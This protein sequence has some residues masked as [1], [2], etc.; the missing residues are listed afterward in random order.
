MGGSYRLTALKCRG[1][2]LSDQGTRLL[3][4]HMVLKSYINLSLRISLSHVVCNYLFGKSCLVTTSEM[5]WSVQ[6]SILNAGE[7]NWI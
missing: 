4:F 3:E 7:E 1:D 5:S 2:G 6:I